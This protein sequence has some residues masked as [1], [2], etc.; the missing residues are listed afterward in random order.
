MMACKWG[1]ELV[2]PLAENVTALR[3]AAFKGQRQQSP[4]CRREGK[5]APVHPALYLDIFEAAGASST[6]L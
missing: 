6:P 5:I 1:A 4:S 3:S 2:T